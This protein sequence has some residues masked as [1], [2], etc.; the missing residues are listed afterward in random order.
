MGSRQEGRGVPDGGRDHREEAGK[1]GNISVIYIRSAFVREWVTV[2][3]NSISIL[4]IYPLLQ[5]I[6][7]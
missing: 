3:E 6:I 5:L 4:I 1:R 2:C 7:L